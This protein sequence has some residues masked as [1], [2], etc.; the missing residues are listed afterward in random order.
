MDPAATAGTTAL[1]LNAPHTTGHVI[2]TKKHFQKPGVMSCKLGF[3]IPRTRMYGRNMAR[4]VQFDMRSLFGDAVLTVSL[5]K[6][7]AC[8]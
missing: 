6:V 8:D 5:R 4:I 7:Q 2:R 3:S 1:S